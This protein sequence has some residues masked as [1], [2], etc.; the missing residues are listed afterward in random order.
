MI[1]QPE[2]LMPWAK[3][4]SSDGRD[5]LEQGRPSRVWLLEVAGPPKSDFVKLCQVIFAFPISQGNQIVDERIFL[6]LEVFQL[7]LKERMAKLSYHYFSTQKWMNLGLDNQWLLGSQRDNQALILLEDTQGL[8]NILARK[9]QCKC[10]Q[11]SRSALSKRNVSHICNC[12]SQFKLNFNSNSE[13]QLP[14]NH[15]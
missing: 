3:A 6:F 8:W 12:T 4:G 15:T 5:N 14:N 13:F 1:F 9:F 2:V 10:D 11:A 7:I